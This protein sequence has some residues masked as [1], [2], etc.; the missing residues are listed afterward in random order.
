[1][2]YI[3]EPKVGGQL[4]V[5]LMSKIICHHYVVHETG[6]DGVLIQ[7]SGDVALPS[8]KIDPVIMVLTRF[9]QVKS[10]FVFRK[11][12]VTVTV[13]IKINCLRCKSSK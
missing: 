3:N 1:M 10:G 13:T 5:E 6:V 12:Q 7:V 11:L 4:F 9:T 2:L 8:E